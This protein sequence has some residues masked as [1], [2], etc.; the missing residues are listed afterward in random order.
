[1]CMQKQREKYL[2]GVDV[3]VEMA[4]NRGRLHASLLRRG[5]EG[6]TD[7]GEPAFNHETTGEI[8]LT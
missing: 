8:D 4:A 2:D 3:R 5:A 1:M 6:G 7:V